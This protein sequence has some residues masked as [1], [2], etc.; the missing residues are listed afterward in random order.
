MQTHTAQAALPL[1]FVQSEEQAMRA[2]FDQRWSRWHRC[3]TFEAAVAD[4]VTARLLSLAVQHGA[5]HAL[6][7]PGG[8]ARRGRR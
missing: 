4:P 3:K 5:T 8:T 1:D 2:L 6:A 7:L